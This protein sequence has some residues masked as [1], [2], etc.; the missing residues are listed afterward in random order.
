MS[1]RTILACLL[2]RESAASVLDFAV[3]FARQHN[4]HLIGLHT[5]EALI[6]Y[7]GIAMHVPDT[8]F[9]RFSESQT[10]ESEA[11]RGIFEARTRSED[12]VSEWRLLKA[13]TS[14]AADRMI[15]SA[16]AADLVVMPAQMTSTARSD[17]ANAQARVIQRG[18]RPVIVVPS[19]FSGEMSLSRIVLGWSNTREAS[20]AAHD[21][22]RIAAEGARIDIVRVDGGRMDEMSDAVAIELAQALDRHG[23]LA[24]VVHR[25]RA[26]SSVSE[27]LQ[28]HALEQGAD[29]IC[30]GAFGHSRAYD[31][32]IGAVTWELL[33]DAKFPVLFSA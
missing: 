30:A 1:I 23:L 19:E 25:D 4:A 13:E 11:I 14:S 32:V 21:M 2:D 22:T 3:P 16:H 6:V 12:F 18:G 27:V 29:L 24:K 31:F 20:R 26:G 5:I 33:R 8:A 7:P 28:Q 17:Q 15:E 10:E 9:V